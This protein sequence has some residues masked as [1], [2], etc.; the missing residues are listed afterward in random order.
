MDPIEHPA[1]TQFKRYL[2]TGLAA[3]LPTVI[4]VFI[5]WKLFEFLHTSLGQWVNK[6]LV[7]VMNIQQ[8][9]LL[10]VI[11]NI[12]SLLMLVILIV[13]TGFLITTYFGSAVFGRAEKFTSSLP[14]IRLIYPTI[15]QVTD[16]FLAKQNVRFN[17]VVAVEY[18]RKGLYS[19]AFVTGGGFPEMKTPE[20]ENV[21]SVFVPSSPTPFTGYTLLVSEKELITLN[22]S[23]DAALRFVISGGVLNPEKITESERGQS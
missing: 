21:V 4:T 17:R 16:F 18:P 11:G 3:L 12:I 13:G 10:I 2:I 23:V 9:S 20:G 22:I 5:L 19:L 1:W 8:G 7:E 6:F 14:I 15:K